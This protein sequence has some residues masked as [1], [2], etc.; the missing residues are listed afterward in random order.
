[1]V[2]SNTLGIIFPNSYD[3]LVPDLVKNRT[4][5]SIPFAGRYHLIDFP[6]SGMVNAGIENVT[7]ITKSNYRSLMEHLG[8][9]R[10]WDLSRKTGGLN[11][12]PPFAHANN[13][14]YHGRVEALN[15][16]IEFLEQQKERY[17]V[18][19]DCHVASAVDYSDLIE[20]HV[21]SGADATMVYERAPIA[22]AIKSDNYT[23]VMNEDARITEIRCNDYRAGIQN[24]FMNIII[25]DRDM[26]ITM[27]KDAMMRGLV[28]LERDIFARCLNVLHV[29]G[30]EY[31]GYRARVCDMKSFFNENQRLI[32][33]ANLHALFPKE[34]PVYTKVRDAA[35][36]R[37]AMDARVKN[38]LVA[39]GCIIE[40]EVENC[41][42]F[43]GVKISKG[44]VV[45]NCV[46]MKDCV[47][48]EGASLNHVVTDKNVTISMGKAMSGTA[49]YPVYIDKGAT[50]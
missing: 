16:I 37:Y 42:L 11:L 7:V 9:G 5:G 1:M 36:V 41:V 43:R 50:V 28:Y 23:F 31:T 46:I 38:S 44:A 13:K 20:T 26:L 4:V 10:E 47:V 2:N 14:V 39:D 27:V 48:E 24:L 19:S 25:M 35:P 15:S 3:N 32:D 45:K 12:V 30:Y 17:V 18:I 40:G 49:T 34:R 33:P 29:R 8:N 22:D 6:L 21:K